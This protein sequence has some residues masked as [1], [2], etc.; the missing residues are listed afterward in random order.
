MLCGLYGAVQRSLGV[1]IHPRLAWWVIVDQLS[2]VAIKQPR[3]T[4]SGADLS[5]FCDVL[6]NSVI[7]VQNVVIISI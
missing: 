3:I 4:H 2:A 1:S 7:Q 5:V 6:Q